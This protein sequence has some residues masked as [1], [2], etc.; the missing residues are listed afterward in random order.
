MKKLILSGILL[1]AATATHGQGRLVFSNLAG[2][3]NAPI[4]WSPTGQAVKPPFVADLYFSTTTNASTDNLQP[5]GFNELF[6]T[7]TAGGGG[8]FLG[9]TRTMTNV[10]A[11][12]ILAQVRVWDSTLGA[13]F[14]QG[15]F[16]PSGYSQPFLLTLVE[17]PATPVS[18]AVQP[19]YLL[20]FGG[21]AADRPSVAKQPLTQ[22]APVGA[23]VFFGVRATNPAYL[24]RYS[25]LSY[26]WYFNLTNQLPGA[27]GASLRLTNVQPAQSGGYHV[28]VGNVAGETSSQVAYLGVVDAALEAPLVPALAISNGVGSNFV[29]Q[30][31]SN[32]T[33]LWTNLGSLTPTNNP[34]LYVDGSATNVPSRFYRLLQVP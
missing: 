16:G 23:T 17:P 29:L 24:A 34:Q 26:R 20:P 21:S 28:M 12:V 9:G 27:T 7:T 6:S 32:L 30:A 18:M 11:G 25:E 15:R 14:E 13:T 2:G 31:A 3:V 22:N 8:Y 1:A 10:P 19:F 4:K 33:A 5:A